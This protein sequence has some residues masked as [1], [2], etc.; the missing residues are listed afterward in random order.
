MIPEEIRQWRTRVLN[1]TADTTRAMGRSST[2]DDQGNTQTWYVS[3]SPA[4]A[5]AKRT[6]NGTKSRATRPAE[7]LSRRKPRSGPRANSRPSPPKS[8]KMN[9]RGAKTNAD[10]PNRLDLIQQGLI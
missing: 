3:N 5:D 9:W 2:P 10:N 6:R 7:N 4:I 1:S 8:W